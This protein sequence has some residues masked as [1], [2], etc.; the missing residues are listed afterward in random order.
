MTMPISLSGAHAGQSIISADVPGGTERDRLAQAARQFEAIFMRQMLASARKADLGG[1]DL[2]GGK[3]DDTFREM[4]D[5]RFA[6]AAAE[7]GSI[8]LAAMIEAQLAR[9]VEPRRN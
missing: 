4:R 8:G 2:F 7:T 3:S 1:D 6:E 5:A 9:F